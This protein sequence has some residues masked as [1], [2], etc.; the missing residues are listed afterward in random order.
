MIHRFLKVIK[1]LVKDP[2]HSQQTKWPN[3]FCKLI[4]FK[5]VFTIT[6][7]IFHFHLFLALPQSGKNFKDILKVGP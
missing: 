2:V 5:K 6:V 3:T 4:Y 7:F 1:L